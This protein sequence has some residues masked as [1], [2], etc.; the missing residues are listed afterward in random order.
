MNTQRVRN[1]TT[2]IL[3]TEIKHIYE[4]IEYIIGEQGI[5]THHLPAANKALRPY[6][7]EKVKEKRFWDE[8][9]DTKHTGNIDIVL[10]KKHEK[11]L[12]WERFDEEIGKFWEETMKER[13]KEKRK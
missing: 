4:D 13:M 7:K 2:G 8:K 6:L 5:M 11:K 10:M 3:H 9:Y 12:F 1:L